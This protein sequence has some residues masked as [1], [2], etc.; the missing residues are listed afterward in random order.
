[1]LFYDV[2]TILGIVAVIMTFVGYVPYIS[3]IVKGKTKPHIYSWLVWSLD[4]FIIFILQ[5]T[6]GAGTGA[7]VTLAAGLMCSTVLV[8]TFIRKN[9]SAITTTDT[10]FLIFACIALAVWL[11]AKQPLI[12]ALLITLVDALGF[13]PTIR[14][15]WI[16]PYSE[17][18]TFYIIITIRFA[19]ALIAV[20]NYSIIT[21]LYPGVWFVANGLFLIMLTIRRK[22]V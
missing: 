11:F 8:L 2:K 15:S 7:F 5:I 1:M 12:S 17:N 6:H 4:A 22:T 10:T 20:Q 21:L 16:K 3:S 18:I 14:K 9:K 13:I 19:F